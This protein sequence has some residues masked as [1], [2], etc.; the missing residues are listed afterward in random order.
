[1]IDKQ[2]NTIIFD[3]GGVL[4]NID[5]EATI[6]SFWKLGVDNFDEMYSQAAQSDL[7]NA[8]ETGQISGQN[9]VHSLMSYLPA[10][11]SEESVIEAWNAMILDVPESSIEI[12][13]K[14]KLEGYKIFLL[15]NTNEI[16]ID[17]ALREWDKVSV[18]RPIELFDH[19]YLS[20]EIH[21]HKPDREIFEFVVSEQS[22]NPSTTL[23][24]DDS[25]QHIEG[26]ISVGINTYHLAKGQS[27]ASVFS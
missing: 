2:I 19:V 25:I 20:H 11:T 3:F 17:Q 18:E 5:Y 9:F 8:L 6:N 7:F 26:A 16:H 10:G 27:V 12:L 21:M 24:I 1:M 4:I 13:K 15:S 14:L 22:L 23:F